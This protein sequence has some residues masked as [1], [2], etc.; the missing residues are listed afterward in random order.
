MSYYH[1]VAGAVCEQ[2]R[3]PAEATFT[4]RKCGYTWRARFADKCLSCEHVYLTRK[5]YHEALQ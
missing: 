4:C 3:R 2:R 1:A 5:V